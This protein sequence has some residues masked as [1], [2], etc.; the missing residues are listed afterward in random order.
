MMNKED[1]FHYRDVRYLAMLLANRYQ[2][3]EKE[4]I[5]TADTLLRTA[6]NMAATDM[7]LGLSGIMPGDVM[8]LVK[9]DMK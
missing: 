1:A 2:M 7:F 9:V 3:P 6:D 4:L 8:L 5:N